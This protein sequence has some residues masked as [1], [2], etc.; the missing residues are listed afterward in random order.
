MY[1]INDPEIGLDVIK[2][3]NISIKT[4]KKKIQ[5]INIEQKLFID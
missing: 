3:K 4:F 5:P 2:P 1:Y